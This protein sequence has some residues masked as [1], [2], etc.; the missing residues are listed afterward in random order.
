MVY[1]AGFPLAWFPYDRNDR[2]R[3][4]RN[5]RKSGF[6][7]LRSLRSYGNQ[8][9]WKPLLRSLRSYGNHS[10][11][12]CD[13]ME[14]KLLLRKCIRFLFVCLFI[15]QPDG[16]SVLLGTQIG[17]LKE[18]NLITGQVPINDCINLFSSSHTRNLQQSLI[19]IT[20]ASDHLMT[21]RLYWLNKTLLLKAPVSEHDQ[22]WDLQTGL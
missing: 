17:E 21:P 20:L 22:L 11:D 16:K 6:H 1:L 10:C 13:H 18:Y 19:V 5:D 2:S 4:D 3:N 8:A 15:F 14:T 9:I 12:R 7:M